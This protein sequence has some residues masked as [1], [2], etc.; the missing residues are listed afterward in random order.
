MLQKVIIVLLVLTVL[1]IA[2]AALL[3]TGV[4][5]SLSIDAV[6]TAISGLVTLT[7]ALLAYI[8]NDHSSR[9][10]AIE[11]R[12]QDISTVFSSRLGVIEGTLDVIK[13]TLDLK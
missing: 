12:M 13:A 8:L 10:A 4:A 1:L 2:Y 5:G 11:K 3:I 9:L 7:V 6:Q